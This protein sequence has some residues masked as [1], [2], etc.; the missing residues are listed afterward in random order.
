MSQRLTPRQIADRARYYGLDPQAVQAVGRSEGYSG[1]MGDNYHAFGPFQ[2]NDA[3]GVLTGKFNGWTPQQKQEW[4]WSQQGVDF[5]LG[6]MARVAKGKYGADAVRALVSQYERPKDI[7]GEVNRSLGYLNT[8]GGGAPPSSV[9]P[10][11]VSPIGQPGQVQQGSQQGI[12]QAL[13]RVNGGDY[14]GFYQQLGQTLKGQSQPSP[15][16]GQLGHDT[17][18]STFPR[19]PMHVKPGSPVANQTSV[20]TEHQTMGLAGFPARDYFAPSGS[21]AVAPIAGKVVRLSG[22][23]P[24]LGPIQGPHGPLGWSVYI[25][26]ADG[27][28][29]FLTHMGS[30]NVKV[31]Q[32]VKAGQRIGTVADYQKYGTPSHIH[33]GRH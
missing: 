20:G 25:Q 14:T 12:L 23:D 17:T 2:M 31:G 5:A 32:T 22:H 9:A 11:G 18:A 26:G 21:A 29:Y 30:R 27:H 10:A 3:G 33:M 13:G 16:A 8:A 4:A 19:Q 15:V 24:R 6:G 7:P 28:E 1:A